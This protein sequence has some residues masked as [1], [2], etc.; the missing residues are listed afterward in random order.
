MPKVCPVCSTTYPDGNVFCAADGSTLRAA[1]VSADLIGSV[2]ADR[3][4]VTDFLG[5]GGMGRVYR[6]RHVRLPQQAAIKVLRREQVT[7]AAAVARFNREAANASRINHEC[8]ARVFDYGET[9]DGLIYLAMEYVA[10]RTLHAVLAESGALDP[11]RAATIVRCIA[12]A[13]DAAHRLGIIHRDLK[14]DNVMVGARDASHR[15][16]ADEIKV[17]DFGI[18][19]AL[20]A[21]EG[22]AALTRT[23]YVVG[24]PEFMSPEQLLGAPLDLRSDVYALAL[25]A[26]QCLT[27]V[28][29][30]DTTTPEKGLTSRLVDPLRRL[31]DARPTVQWPAEVEAVFESG[32]ARD[33]AGRPA[34]AGEFA[35]QLT[36]AIERW[37][38]APRPVGAVPA[39]VPPA[40]AAAL[41][42]PAGAVS[43]ASAAPVERPARARR[44][45]IVAGVVGA[46]TL[47]VLVGGWT[48][49]K[50]RADAEP[51][52]PTATVPAAATPTATAL[53][54]ATASS[55]PARPTGA[56]TATVAAVTPAPKAT[57]ARERVA[58]APK[59]PSEEDAPASSSSAR[60][61]LDSL[62]TALDPASADE[63]SARAALSLLRAMAPRFTSAS[64][65]TWAQIR[66]AQASVLSGDTGG[67]CVALTGARRTARSGAETGTIRRLSEQLACGD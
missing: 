61:V 6:A 27:G 30:F 15:D 57:V 33:P 20:N 63:A 67:A 52:T 5:E 56:P 31:Q 42:V 21:E 23:G 39:R 26:Y 2:V 45:S 8:V 3:Y 40:A 49:L 32:L 25:V 65:R 43:P 12:D 18:A 17:V 51:S 1:D 38:I 48:V 59:T 66:R 19:K 47:V 60:G 46:L 34:S 10:G 50:R 24:T 41:P 37:R 28:L 29:P 13:L 44:P 62:G 11:Q 64:D 16:G 55:P 9:S 53:P 7:D 22:G 36:D 4:L 35:R 58:P 54:S 14:P